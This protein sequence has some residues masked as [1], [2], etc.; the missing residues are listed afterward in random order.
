MSARSS[1]SLEN[2]SEAG[3]FFETS[4]DAASR[5]ALLGR[6]NG[7][8]QGNVQGMAVVNKT[9]Q[10][11][12][13]VQT[14]ELNIE[15]FGDGKSL[16]VTEKVTNPSGSRKAKYDPGMQHVY[17]GIAVQFRPLICVISKN[18]LTR[19]PRT[20]WLQESDENA[21]RGH[22]AEA[23]FGEKESKFRVV[24]ELNHFTFERIS[25]E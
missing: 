8:A 15:F 18:L 22:G 19:L 20:Y 9:G 1:A 6:W 4:V 21:L 17:E 3:S 24:S 23:I 11:I 14:S 25:E 13:S 10:D 12:S 2:V 16:K 5:E 7:F